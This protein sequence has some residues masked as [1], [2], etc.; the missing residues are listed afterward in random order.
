MQYYVD[1]YFLI[2]C[3]FLIWWTILFVLMALCESNCTPTLIFSYILYLFLGPCPVTKDQV[4][5]GSVPHLQMNLTRP[6]VI[7]AMNLSPPEGINVSELQLFVEF[8]HWSFGWINAS[9]SKIQVSLDFSWTNTSPIVSKTE[10]FS[11]L[12]LKSE[13]SKL[14]SSNICRFKNLKP[15]TVQI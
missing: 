5:C 4:V 1:N 7:T 3:M 11:W 14:S 9:M 8:Y 6:E 2:K 13:V 12:H 10:I 15:H